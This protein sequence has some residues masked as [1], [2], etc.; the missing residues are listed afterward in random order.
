MLKVY[1]IYCYYTES[2]RR[3]FQHICVGNT[4]RTIGYIKDS[5]PSCHLEWTKTTRECHKHM[6]DYILFKAAT[7]TLEE[8]GS[9]CAYQSR[10]R[11]HLEEENHHQEIHTNGG[12]N[13]TLPRN[14]S[15]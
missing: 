9:I 11:H 13:K 14:K 15:I 5:D 12:V 10:L 4:S 6:M 2:A 1:V 7:D 3:N 8:E